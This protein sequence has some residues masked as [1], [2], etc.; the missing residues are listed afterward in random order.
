MPEKRGVT[1]AFTDY[2]KYLPEEMLPTFWTDDERAMLTGTTLRPAVSAKHN[3]LYREFEE[4][5]TL[6]SKIKWCAECWWDDV[7]GLMTF[8]DWLQVD[9]MYRS[10]ALEFPGFGDCMAPCIDMANHLSG[11]GTM[12]IYEV[13]RHGNA[14]LMLRDGKVVEKGEE[15]SITYGDA[16]GACEMIFSYGFLEESMDSANELFLDL[17]I[18]KDDPLGKAKATISDAPPGY[19]I[20]KS[21]DG[22]AWSGDFVWLICVNEED[23]LDFAIQ[24]TIDGEL[25]L[26]SLWKNEEIKGLGRFKELLE[27]D[28][29]WDIFHLRA[30]S[31]LQDRI[32]AQLQTLYAF[33]DE[34]NEAS[35]GDEGFV[36]DRPWRLAQKLRSLEG[37]LM[38][39]AYSH[40]EDLVRPR[41]ISHEPRSRIGEEPRLL[42]WTL[43]K[44]ALAQKESV[45]RYLGDADQSRDDDEEDFS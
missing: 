22:I 8:D 7:D 42:T 12:A 30:V 24:Q 17:S 36:R 45:R 3:A 15:V 1:S 29:M 32:A 4:F 37:S 9:A 28:P 13:D 41:A 33:E 11:N 20:Y 44:I 38:E 25:E 35:H 18:P 21:G 19:K 31:V 23:G 2:I 40:F 5:R 39:E 34:F 27:Q 26:V 6:T 10:R 16:K 14:I 43:Q